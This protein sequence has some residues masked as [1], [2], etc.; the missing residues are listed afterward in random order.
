VKHGVRAS[1]RSLLSQTPHLSIRQIAEATG[2]TYVQVKKARSFLADPE[3][4][5]LTKQKLLRSKGVKPAAVV[6]AERRA[7]AADAALP[8]LEL[9][10]R[11]MSFSQI[12]RK[13]RLTKGQ[14]AGHVRRARIASS[15]TP[16]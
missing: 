11:G 4:H 9:R 3:R 13:L 1:V 15:K 2:F 5:R 12:A 6:V 8:I 10:K 16:V 7:V 14:V